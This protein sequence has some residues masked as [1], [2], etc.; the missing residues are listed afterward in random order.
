MIKIKKYSSNA[1]CKQGCSS[2]GRRIVIFGFYWL[3][4]KP[5]E[6]SVR[7]LTVSLPASWDNGR[8]CLLLFQGPALYTKGTEPLQSGLLDFGMPCLRRS[9]LPTLSRLSIT[10]KNPLIQNSFFDDL[11][12]FYGILV[13]FTLF[14]ILCKLVSYFTLHGS[15]LFRYFHV[16]SMVH[17]HFPSSPQL[18]SSTRYYYLPTHSIWLDVCIL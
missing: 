4:T 15:N 6:L 9:V 13:H 3:L 16:C 1:H 11:I 18:P 7:S 2:D 10:V 17:T 5:W 12:I 14:F 8:H